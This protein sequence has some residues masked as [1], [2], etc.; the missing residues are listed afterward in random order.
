MSLINIIL[1]HIQW[2]LQKDTP[3]YLITLFPEFYWL[4]F[5]TYTNPSNTKDTNRIVYLNIKN[6]QSIDLQLQRYNNLHTLSLYGL[7][8][9]VVYILPPKLEILYINMCDHEYLPKLPTTLRVLN[10]SHC[11]IKKID[12]MHCKNLVTLNC[13]SNLLEEMP[14]IN[15]LDI[16]YF[17]C[18]SN[19]FKYKTI[20]DLPNSI[21]HLNLKL[22]NIN[23][24]TTIPQNIIIINIEYNKIQKLPQLPDCLE[25]LIAS[26]NKI[27]ELPKLPPFLKNIQIS[28]NYIT[29]IPN[30]PPKLEYLDC[31]HNEIKSIQPIPK[32]IKVFYCNN[33]NI[34]LLPPI[35]RGIVS[36]KFH[37]NIIPEQNTIEFF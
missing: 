11:M 37:N 19:E 23:N 28:H 32:T 34:E 10:C 12:V 35:P 7:P 29:T 8:K 27:Q 13:Y 3:E 6:L 31:S 14:Q 22:N 36:M 26:Y 33:N 2:Y 16:K 4:D 25:V 1:D 21:E 20:G 15:E 9:T 24:I 18:G 5:T 30:I 17:N